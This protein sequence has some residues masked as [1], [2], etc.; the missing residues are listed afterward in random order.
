MMN[1]LEYVCHEFCKS[2][3]EIM[4]NSFSKKIEVKVIAYF[5]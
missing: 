5:R 3:Q 4:S 2:E 1:T